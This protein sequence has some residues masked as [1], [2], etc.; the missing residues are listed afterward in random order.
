MRAHVAPAALANRDPSLH[1]RLPVGPEE[2]AQLLRVELGLLEWR[3]V[4]AAR[5]AVMAPLDRSNATI[6]GGQAASATA[7]EALS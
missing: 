1:E 3:E 5:T 6:F 7:T 4:P 2:C